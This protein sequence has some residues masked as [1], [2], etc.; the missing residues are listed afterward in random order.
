M[1]CA[2]TV[3]KLKPGT[4]DQFAANFGPPE[5]SPPSGWVR[6]HMLRK[7]GDQDEVV[8]FGFFDGTIEE[9]E[10]SQK[11]HGYEERRDSVDELVDSVISNGVYE[12][13]RSLK[14]EGARAE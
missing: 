14:P 3:R 8:T 7:L 11:Q 4:Y 12:V 9:L 1:L 6:F 13:A 5:D 2:L 10:Q